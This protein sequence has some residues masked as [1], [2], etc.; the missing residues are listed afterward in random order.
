[1]VASEMLNVADRLLGQTD[2]R[3]I[4]EVVVSG[5]SIEEIA[6]MLR[7]R[8]T[9]TTCD[10]A[11]ERIRDG[12]NVLADAWMPPSRRRE[13]TILSTRSADAKPHVMPDEK[14]SEIERQR[15]AHAST[16]GVVYGAQKIAGSRRHRADG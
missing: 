6:A 4:H 16:S 9:R 3:V 14:F 12:L 8:V 5:R 10:V 15:V 13:S 2:A 11:R 7:G 1:M